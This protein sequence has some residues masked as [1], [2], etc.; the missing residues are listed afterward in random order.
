MGFSEMPSR[1]TYHSPVLRRVLRPSPLML[2]KDGQVLRRHLRQELV[3]MD[4]LMS[5]LR[6]EGITSPSEVAESR[7]GWQYQRE[8]KKLIRCTERLGY[9]RKTPWIGTSFRRPELSWVLAPG[10]GTTASR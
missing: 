2:F 6:E 3:T 1:C 5:K 8:E 10:N 4:E 9:Q 7:T